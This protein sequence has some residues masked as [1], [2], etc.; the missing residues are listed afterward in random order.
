MRPPGFSYARSAD[1]ARIAW[2]RLGHGPSLV[3]VSPVPLSNISGDWSIPLMRDVFERL[4]TSFDLIL[5]DGRGTGAS[6]RSV[7]DF[8]V[9]AQTA[10]IEAVMDAAE[11]E[12]SALLAMYLACPAALTLAARAPQRVS[13]LILF[14][15]S[16][17]GYRSVDRV[18][19][20]ALLGLIDQDWE[21]FT[22]TAALDWM[23][24]GAGDSGRLVAESFRTATTPA[25]A[26]AAISEY[27]NTDLRA[28]LPGVAAETL[29]L[30]RRDGRQVPIE[31]S[32]D[33]ASG[34]PNGR[35]HIL[36]GDSATLFFDDPVGTVDVIT[37][38]VQPDRLRPSRTP[39]AAPSAAPLTAR[40]Q[41]V[42]RAVA[43]GE[44]NAEIAH[45]LGISVHTV[46]RHVANIY[47]KIDAR[48]R[49][50]ATAWAL[51]NG[52]G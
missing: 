51:R 23:G 16:D 37:S 52:L 5:Y 19:T 34:V 44:S 10:D 22:K 21:L 30:H 41:E 28:V 29:V 18:G 12:R 8:S 42:V 39:G 24:W 49:A 26:K 47:R 35:L 46:E 50:D 9:Q 3:V 31:Q 14:G 45:S 27:A 15:G 40:E 32:A 48:G 20:D 1:G 11:V 6:Q 2:M 43:A 4:S 33:L 13:H 17:Q 36:E 25:I 7:E 38:F